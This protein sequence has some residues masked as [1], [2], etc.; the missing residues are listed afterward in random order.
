[1]ELC[2]SLITIAGMAFGVYKVVRWMMKAGQLSARREQPLTPT[3]LKVLEES[4]ARLI[5]DLRLAADECVA[6]VDEALAE[7]EARLAALKDSSLCQSVAAVSP[8][9]IE[10]SPEKK[11][12][13]S[14]HPEQP[15]STDTESFEMTSELAR[16][17]GLT[18]GEV[19]L[20][21][22]LRK[23]AR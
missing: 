3:D 11:L 6:K 18:T 13:E 7:A 21:R 8:A 5:A 9:M 1:M 2:I 22:G 4:A 15:G 16:E 20:I 12:E 10:I 23:I 14:V 17:M 19:E